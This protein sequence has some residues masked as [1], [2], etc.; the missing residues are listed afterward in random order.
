MKNVTF[1]GKTLYS[2]LH[3]VVPALQSIAIDKDLGFPHFTAIDSLFNEGIHIPRLGSGISSILPR[4]IKFVSDL[5]KDVLL[6][7]TPDLYQSNHLKNFNPF[8]F[9]LNFWDLQ[10]SIHSWHGMQEINFLGLA[11]WNFRAKL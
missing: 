6:F 10:E 9:P 4:L 5:K 11:M 3:A 2:A 8:F 7:E 1:S